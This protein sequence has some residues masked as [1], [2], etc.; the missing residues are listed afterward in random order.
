L[1]A[2]VQKPAATS[3]RNLYIEIKKKC[4]IS[5]EEFSRQERQEAWDKDLTKEQQQVFQNLFQASRQQLQHQQPSSTSTSSLAAPAPAA[6][7]QK[8]LQGS[9]TEPGAMA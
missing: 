3:W 6:S 9:A 2:V 7:P 1:A 8:V 5:S 4:S